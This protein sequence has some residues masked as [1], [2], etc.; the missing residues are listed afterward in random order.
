MDKSANYFDSLKAPLRASSLLTKIKL[1]VILTDPKLRAYSW[2][3]VSVLLWGPTSLVAQTFN[4]HI[5]LICKTIKS[6]VAQGELATKKTSQILQ[7]NIQWNLSTLISLLK[8]QDCVIFQHIISKNEPSETTYS[9]Y[10][11]I[12]AKDLTADHKFNMLNAKCLL[13][14]RYAEAMERWL[15]FYNP[16]QVRFILTCSFNPVH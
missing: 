8:N 7:K 9:F 16:S 2:Y 10:D 15:Q 13:P 6:V 12:S 11:V 14:G 1:I 4:I 3:Q 5:K